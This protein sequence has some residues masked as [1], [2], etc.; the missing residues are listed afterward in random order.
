MERSTATRYRAPCIRVREEIMG[1]LALAAAFVLAAAGA[2]AARSAT[3]EPEPGCNV[4]A[5]TVTTPAGW[6]AY[7]APV[8]EAGREGCVFAL[9]LDERNLAGMILVG[10]H[11]EALPYLAEGDAGEILLARLR[12][13]LA[14]D[15]GLELGA[16]P[17]FRNDALAIA[18]GSNVDRATMQVYAADAEDGVGPREVGFVLL[19]APGTYF[20]A[21]V[22]TPAQSA[23]PELWAANQ[24]GLRVLLNSLL[25]RPPQP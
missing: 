6:Q 3:P 20:T 22:L 14:A 24:D 8:R 1:R 16:T 2:A 18:P 9:P 7:T 4:R 11:A 17:I 15:Q 12:R 23:E 5:F 19:H 10:A 13:A 25:P 21:V